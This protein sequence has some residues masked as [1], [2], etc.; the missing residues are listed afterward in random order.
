MLKRKVKKDPKRGSFFV[1]KGVFWVKKISGNNRLKLLFAS[2]EARELARGTMPYIPLVAHPLTKPIGF[3]P[4]VSRVL[5]YQL[6]IQRPNMCSKHVVEKTQLCEY[7]G[8][9]KKKREKDEKTSVT[10]NS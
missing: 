6:N 9:K 10:D 3:G 5:R 8:E 4:R 7:Y 1:K 2:F